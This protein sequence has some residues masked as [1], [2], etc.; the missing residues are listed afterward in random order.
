MNLR[1]DCFPF[2]NSDVLN[3]ISLHNQTFRYC[4]IVKCGDPFILW[5]S[6]YL[7]HVHV[8]VFLW[9]T[10]KMFSLLSFSKE[11]Q[12]STWHS[13]ILAL[14]QD[15]FSGLRMLVKLESKRPWSN[16][17]GEALSYGEK[18]DL[19][20]KVSLLWWAT[21]WNSTKW[22]CKV[23]YKVQWVIGWLPFQSQWIQNDLHCPLKPG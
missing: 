13:D 21:H 9:N 14:T 12:R 15:N 18:Q 23:F 4:C 6:G 5:F 8:K 11:S 1:C 19:C 2:E 17:L 16:P 7:F 22:I 20:K 3:L 10:M